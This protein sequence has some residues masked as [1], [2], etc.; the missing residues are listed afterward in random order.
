M[1]STHLE[2]W[3]E[4]VV[5]AYIDEPPFAAPAAGGAVGCDVELAMTVLESIGVRHVELQLTTFGELLSGVADGRWTMNTPLF[6]TPERRRQA[7]FS[8]PV[9]ALRDGLIVRPGAASTLIGYEAVAS[10]RARLGVVSGQVQYQTALRAGVAADR[11]WTFATQA[12]AI[13]ALL[14]G[15]IDAYASTLLGKRTLV[16]QL[17]HEALCAIEVT[18]SPHPIP[19]GAFSFAHDSVMLRQ[20]LDTFLASYLGSPAHRQ[21]VKAHGLS[22]SEI[23]PV[24]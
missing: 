19:V 9:W 16:R 7:A 3:Q 23:D 2:P 6:V 20:R 17:A 10:Q 13:D 8:R 21:Q 18:P 11:V 1:T 14:A 12:A 4:R 24:V 5:F 22:A 15:A